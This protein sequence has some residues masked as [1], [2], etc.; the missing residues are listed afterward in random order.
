MWSLHV[1]ATLEQSNITRAHDDLIFESLLLFEKRRR[2][3]FERFD[4]ESSVDGE[5]RR[6]ALSD[7]DML[8]FSCSHPV[9]SKSFM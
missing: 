6:D 2:M 3:D 4:G 9:K 8:R 1:T 5:F 7:K